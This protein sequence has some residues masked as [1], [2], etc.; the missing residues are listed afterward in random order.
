MIS[1]NERTYVF[2]FL[3]GLNDDYAHIH[4]Q[5][6]IILSSIFNVY[7]LISQEENIRAL[8]RLTSRSSHLL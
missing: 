8:N 1:H 6:V 7:G 2:C 4:S 3:M 5:V